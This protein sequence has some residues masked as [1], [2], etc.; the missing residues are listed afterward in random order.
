MS[1]QGPTMVR[2]QLGKRLRRMREDAG[3]TM[4]DVSEAKLCSVSK[5]IRIESGKV[6]VRVGDVWALCR[7]YGVHDN[8]TVDALT[9]LAEGTSQKAWWEV[10]SGNL[11]QEGFGLYLGLEEGADSILTWGPEL[12]HGLLQTTS[13]SRSV[14]AAVACLDEMDRT[15]ECVRLRA[16]RQ[17]RF[18]ARAPLA[19]VTAIIGSSALLQEV[20]GPQV[21]ADQRE[22]LLVLAQDEHFDIRVLPWSA[23]AHP[24]MTSGFTIFDF[25]RADDPAVVYVE[26]LAGATYQEQEREVARFRR[27]FQALYDRSIP[28]KEY[29]A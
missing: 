25:V 12:V 11:I 10:Y 2:R 19:R 15:E 24:A 21:Q 9:A 28:I 7:F 8:E 22:H 4:R 14:N 29:E 18:F 13:Y 6:E 5:V 1:I 27:A 26:T 16:A 3:K 17:E 20:G 23:G